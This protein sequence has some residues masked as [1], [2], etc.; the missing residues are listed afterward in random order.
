MPLSGTDLKRLEKLL[1]L[2]SSDQD[3][4]VLGSVSAIKRILDASKSDFHE[5]AK[6]MTEP[7]KVIPVIEYRERIIYQ[8]R[9]VYRDRPVAAPAPVAEPKGY[10]KKYSTA[11]LRAMRVFC[12]NNIE[13]LTDKQKEFISTMDKWLDRPGG[14]L[15]EKQL[16]WLLGLY[17]KC[18]I[19]S[20]SAA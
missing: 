17:E 2:L 5:L 16:E 6:R 3:G 8:D 11:E 12:L 20:A 19:K 4:E 18:K 13:H 15:T 10:D 14:R 7:P 9:I 1:R